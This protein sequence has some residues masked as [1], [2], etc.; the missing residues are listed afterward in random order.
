MSSTNDY[1]TFDATKTIVKENVEVVVNIEENIDHLASLLSTTQTAITQKIP[2]R[3][4]NN[5]AIV[6]TVLNMV[7][8][9]N[10]R[11]MFCS[12]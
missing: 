3:N 7:S 9:L 11:C 6:L 12:L 8:F 5:V 2:F 1:V 10:F 4:I